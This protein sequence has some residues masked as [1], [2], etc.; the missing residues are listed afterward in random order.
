MAMDSGEQ[1]IQVGWRLPSDLYWDL[2][3]LASQRHMSLNRL[4][5]VVLQDYVAEGAPEM[6]AQQGRTPRGRPKAMVSK[7]DRRSEATIA[8]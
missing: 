6:G 5:R 2:S 3:T 1:T 7:A 4:V 8:R